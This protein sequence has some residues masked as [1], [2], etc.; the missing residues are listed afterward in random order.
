MDEPAGYN[1]II[2]RPTIIGLRIVTLLYHLM[3]KFPTA[4]GVGTMIGNQAMAR[5]CLVQAVDRK[6]AGKMVAMAHRHGPNQKA[7]V[8]QEWQMKTSRATTRE[9]KKP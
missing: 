9:S 2:D 4:E 5:S 1:I 7:D 8:K 6:A 3:L